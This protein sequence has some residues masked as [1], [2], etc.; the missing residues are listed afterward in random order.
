[1][2]VTSYVGNGAASR[3]IGL[4]LNGTAPTFVL[5]VPTTGNNKGYRVVGDSTGRLTTTGG[6]FANSIT[7]M[8]ADQITVGT[9]LNAVGV[10]YDVWAIR[11]GTVAP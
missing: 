5:V 8:A 4:S 10:S 1:M 11:P 6:P 7:A 3:N 9:A 2:A